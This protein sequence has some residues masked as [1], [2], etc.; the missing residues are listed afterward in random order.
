MIEAMNNASSIPSRCGLF[1]S[2]PMK[3]NLHGLRF[4]L[5]WNIGLAIAVFVICAGIVRY[6]MISYHA[7]GG[8]DQ[9]LTQDAQIFVSA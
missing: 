4:K 8:A 2:N 5:G 3:R 9:S 6:Q 1:A 7:Y